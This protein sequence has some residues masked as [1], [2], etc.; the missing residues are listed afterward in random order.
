MARMR[1]SFPQAA[2]IPMRD[3]RICLVT[4]RGGHG[5]VVPK[6]CLDYGRTAEQIAL[7]EAWE[8]AGLIG[9]LRAKPLGS[10][11]YEKAGRHFRV[12]LFFMDVTTVV[13]AWPECRWRR[14]HWLLPAEAVA[15]VCQ[16]GLRR[17]LRKVLQ[18]EPGV[19][20]QAC[21]GVAQG[22][23]RWT[24]VPLVPSTLKPTA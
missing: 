13:K 3:G 7:Q 16:P 19:D 14:R 8:E 4:S 9:L 15:S 17:L 12:V 6:G 5:L 22:R 2:A 20:A 10:Y 18:P 1:T 11:R 23:G 21:V 24:S